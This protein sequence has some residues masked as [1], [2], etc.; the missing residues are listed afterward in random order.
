MKRALAGLVVALALAGCAS[1]PAPAA[2]PFDEAAFAERWAEAEAGGFD[3]QLGGPYPPADGVTV[4]VRDRS[5]PPADVVI[6]VCY[7][8][9]FQTQPG[10]LDWWLE[11]HPELLLRDSD[12]EPVVDPAWPD[13]R[14][15]DSSTP[16][17]RAA[18]AEIVGGWLEGC[19]QSGFEAAEL[20][21]LDA[22]TRAEGL[23]MAGTLE[24][25]ATLVAR[26]HAAGLAMAQKNA[27]EIG[28]AGPE[29][30]FDL[31]LTEE[32]SR[33]GECDDYGALYERHLAVEYVGALPEGASFD[34][35]CAAEERPALMVL[36]DLDLTVPSDPAHVVERC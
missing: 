29:A 28:Q 1:A 23:T 35:V 8:N 21:N 33:F 2:E 4:V 34:A 19:A 26:G 11:Q 7:V 31:V 9:A 17:A 14:L 27:L 12:G 13:E 10:E 20:D 5:A 25:A 18:I 22:W 36:R 30:G 16:E 32:C 24:L 15:L 3:Y 6:D